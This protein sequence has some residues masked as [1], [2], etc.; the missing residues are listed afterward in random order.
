M[1]TTRTTRTRAIN[2]RGDDLV[3]AGG[4]ALVV[5]SGTSYFRPGGKALGELREAL[6]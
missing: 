2:Q 6:R 3:D 5:S 4:D 1:K